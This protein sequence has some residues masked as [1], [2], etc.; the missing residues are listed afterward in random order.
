MMN[1][2]FIMN[3][4]EYDEK[5]VAHSLTCKHSILYYT[6]QLQ[7]FLADTIKLQCTTGVHT[8]FSLVDNDHWQKFKRWINYDATD[9]QQS[10]YR[11]AGGA[12]GKLG[13]SV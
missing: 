12:Q 9:I 2:E 8:F 1:H 3:H 13:L 4:Y 10:S 7:L 5:C 6:V 11:E